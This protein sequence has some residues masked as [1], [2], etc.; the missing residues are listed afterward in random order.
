MMMIVM[1]SK[2]KNKGKIKTKK[3]KWGSMNLEMAQKSTSKGWGSCSAVM[4]SAGCHFN[5]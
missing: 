4:L 3:D 5:H 2:I 1:K